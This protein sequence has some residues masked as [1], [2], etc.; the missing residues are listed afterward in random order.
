[1][2]VESSVDKPFQEDEWVGRILQIGTLRVRVDKRDG[3]CAIISIH[4]ETAEHNP[5]ILR[6]VAKEREGC[7]GVYGTIVEPGQVAVEDPV[8]IDDGIM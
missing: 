5:A 3:R 2:L 1:M 8:R 7:L 4:P 6:T